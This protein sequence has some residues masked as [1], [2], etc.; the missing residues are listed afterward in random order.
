MKLELD[1]DASAQLSIL[2]ALEA[3][4]DP[5]LSPEDVDLQLATHHLRRLRDA[6]RPSRNQL[7]AIASMTLNQSDFLLHE[8]N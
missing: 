5:F 7:E 6:M 8:R 3:L 4:T 1:F 2:N